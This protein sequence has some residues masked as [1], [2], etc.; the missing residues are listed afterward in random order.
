VEDLCFQLPYCFNKVWKRNPTRA[1]KRL[2]KLWNEHRHEQIYDIVIINSYQLW[3]YNKRKGD[4]IPNSQQELERLF[5]FV[6]FA[7][8]HE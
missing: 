4:A 5:S 1:V 3:V 6:D 2:N 8:L 7:E